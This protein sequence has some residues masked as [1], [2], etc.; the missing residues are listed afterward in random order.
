METNEEIYLFFWYLNTK[1]VRLLRLNYLESCFNGIGEVFL[2]IGNHLGLNGGF[3]VM[4]LGDKGNWEVLESISAFRNGKHYV[5]QD[6]GM[7][8]TKIVPA[9]FNDESIRNKV[10]E[11]FLEWDAFLERFKEQT[12]GK[13]DISLI[14]DMKGDLT[15]IGKQFIIGE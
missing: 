14:M 15:P 6:K 12:D 5:I 7:T 8:F 10:F 13:F 3:S 4:N 9:F 2:H 11:T 1:S